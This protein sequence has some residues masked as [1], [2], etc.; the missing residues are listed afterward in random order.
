MCVSANVAVVVVAFVVAVVL[1]A[2]TTAVKNNREKLE[3]I[4]NRKVPSSFNRP[5]PCQVV[6]AFIK[7][8]F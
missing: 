8:V 5:C 1:S 4:E 2:T 7:N 6:K 3:K